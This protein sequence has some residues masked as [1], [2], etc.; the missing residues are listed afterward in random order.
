MKKLISCLLSLLI[1]FIGFLYIKGPADVYASTKGTIDACGMTVEY[2]YSDSYFAVASSKYQNPLADISLIA[3]VTS[4]DADTATEFYKALGFKDI[5]INDAFYDNS[6]SD[7]IGLVLAR[8]E[9][10]LNGEKV[11]IIAMTVRGVN[12]RI[13]WA[14]N[15]NVGDSGNHQG[16]ST[17]SKRALEFIEDYY[18]T[19]SLSGQHN[20]VWVQGYSR[21]GAIAYMTARLIVENGLVRTQDNL[22]VYTFNAPNGVIDEWNC[23][24]VYNCVNTMDLIQRTAPASWGFKKYGTIMVFG[25][26]SLTKTLT[27]PDL[28]SEGPLYP[29]QDFYVRKLDFS[30]IMNGGSLFGTEYD[31]QYNI[32]KF[33]TVFFDFF[34]SELNDPLDSKRIKRSLDPV[35]SLTDRETYCKY[36]QTG[37]MYMFELIFGDQ[38]VDLSED[39]TAFGEMGLVMGYILS[40]FVTDC[41]DPEQTYANTIATFETIY[42]SSVDEKRLQSLFMFVGKLFRADAGASSALGLAVSDCPMMATLFG[43]AEY[44]A[45]NHMYNVLL[46]WIRN[47]DASTYYEIDVGFKTELTGNVPVLSGESVKKEGFAATLSCKY[48]S[49]EWIFKG[50]YD[51]DGN[52]VSE[53]GEI[54]VAADKDMSFYAEFEEAPKPT[55]TEPV[56]ELS[57]TQSA[58]KTTDTSVEKTDNETE[59][60]DLKPLFIGIGGAAALSG[61]AAAVIVILKKRKK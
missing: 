52:L 27:D 30:A 33:Y 42:P 57:E 15:F 14:D 49:S 61:I 29:E 35:P 9:A 60:R 44:I 7:K 18:R 39:G 10:V 46:A 38:A 51:A 26:P 54:T 20:K 32:I 17:N 2:E 34:T 43:N 47:D 21:G 4:C 16:F 56:E 28:S 13:E 45:A 1:S 11:N 8:K 6:T 23:S 3:S 55:E 5:V 31:E 25:D 58:D 40:D 36:Y 59:E 37:M 22:F 50:W 19:Y 41:Y 48:D 53:S 24:C 12:Y